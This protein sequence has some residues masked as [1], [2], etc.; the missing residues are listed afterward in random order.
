MKLFNSKIKPAHR[1]IKK[2]YF[3]LIVVGFFSLLWFLIRVVPKPS[4]AAYPCQRA[5]FP[6][7]SAF[8]LWIAGTLFSQSIYSKA[9]LAFAKG[10]HA[11]ALIFSASA[12]IVFI[13]TIFGFQIKDSAY[14]AI[15][16]HRISEEGNRLYAKNLT[17]GTQSIIEPEATVA[18]VRSEKSQ[19]TDISFDD[20]DV[21]IHKAVAMAGG[22][23]TLI[24]E[25]DQVVIKPN[26]IAG[27]SQGASYSNA[28]PMEANGIATD[29]RIIQVVV[30]MVREKNKTGKIVMIEGS[31]YGPT[32]KNINAIGYDKITGLDSIICLDENIAKWYDIN[33]KTLSKVS[34]PKG[35][36]L[37]STSNIYYLNKVYAD[38]DVLISLPCLKSHFLTGITGGIKNVGIGATPVEMYGNGM[39]VNEDDRPGRWN[40]INHGD[41]STQTVS[42]DKW[43]HDFYLCKPVNY[44][45]M[46]G[47]Q[48]ADYGPYPG[49]NTYHLLKDV[50]KNL[51]VIMAG[52]DPL[53]VDATEALITG[54]DPYL[55]GHLVYLGKDSIGCINPARIKIKGV[56]V[57]EIKTNFRE[58]NPGK[59]CKTTDFTAPVVSLS[60]LELKNGQ[61]EIG[62]NS[63]D[64]ITKVEVAYNDT[65]LGPIVVK[66]FDA[67]QY[68]TGLLYP[69][70]GKV[71]ILVYDKFLNCT[72]LSASSTSIR[73]LD[74][75]ENLKI[76]P[77]PAKNYLRVEN[78]FPENQ[79]AQYC[80]FNSSGQKIIEGQLISEINVG[81]LKAGQYFL[82]VSQG[83]NF[84]QQAFLK[85]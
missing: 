60:K 75:F 85:D 25:G 52:K 48:G 27:R 13:V 72:K 28:F 57:H 39:S 26:V 1:K 35:K 30:N 63:S 10:K 73:K 67:I 82:K 31:G 45:I 44:V 11:K 56:Q 21:M 23:D 49:S 19:A 5:A 64:E 74:N 14:S 79:V 6:L 12:L 66:N 46:D 16:F 50:Q 81:Q 47:L 32:R 42:L 18:I 2:S 34:L 62:L 59:K 37:Y 41:F 29:Y 70:I 84:Y 55:I 54:F 76:Y 69:D 77:N 43:I 15:N 51:R 20:I 4:R 71:S 80:I 8:V 38:A 61:L 65:I 36:N 58:D 33:S 9:R 7:A 3:F 53:A 22:F 24:H 17:E 78:P 83:K 68:P 40:H